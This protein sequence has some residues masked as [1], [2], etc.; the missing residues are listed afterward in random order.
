[1]GIRCFFAQVPVP[2]SEMLPPIGQ[3]IYVFW[4]EEESEEPA[5]W[6]KASVEEY[7]CDGK[8]MLQYSCGSKEVVDLS[9]IN[10]KFARKIGRTFIPSNQTPSPQPKSATTNQ[11][12]QYVQGLEHKCKGLLITSPSLTPVQQTINTPSNALKEQQL[13]LDSLSIHPNVSL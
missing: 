12:P 7:H 5:G 9:V 6:Y 11:S 10:W 4:D 2:N 13:T 3:S 8:V 1:M